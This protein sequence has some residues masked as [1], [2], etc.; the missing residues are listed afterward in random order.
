MQCIPLLWHLTINY[1]ELIQIT[2]NWEL[3]T[4]LNVYSCFVPTTNEIAPHYDVVA[5]ADRHEVNF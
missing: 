1:H 5:L 2:I 3:S 4:L